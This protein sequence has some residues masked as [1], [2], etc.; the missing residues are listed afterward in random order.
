M[1][2]TFSS[3]LLL[4][5][6][7][8]FSGIFLIQCSSSKNATSF[9]EGDIQQMI[10]SHQFKFVADRAE[11]LRLRTRELTS[12]YDVLVNKDS[13]ICYLPYFGRAYQAPINPTEGGIQFTSTSFSYAAQ[14]DKGDSWNVDIKPNDQPGIQRL[15]FTIFSN[16]SA[17]L[18]VTNTNKDA[19]SFNGHIENKKS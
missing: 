10:N 19:I 11:P 2:S 4:I 12:G 5:F 16:G 9:K 15:Y 6:I 7:L 13:L 14:E 3:G 1:R 18:H 8:L 17:T